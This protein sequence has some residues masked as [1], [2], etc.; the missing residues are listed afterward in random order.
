VLRLEPDVSDVAV[1]QLQPD[2]SYKRVCGAPSPEV[3]AMLDG[4]R[5]ARRARR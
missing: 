5:R 2:G 3:G 4:V 1:L